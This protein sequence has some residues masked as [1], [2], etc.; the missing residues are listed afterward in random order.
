MGDLFGGRSQQSP[1]TIIN[2]APAPK[3]PAPMPDPD[4]PAARE[5]RRRAVGDVLSRAGRSSTILT[6]R[7]EREDPYTASQLGA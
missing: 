3:P 6:A 7:E 5:A 1:Q 4:S 2:E